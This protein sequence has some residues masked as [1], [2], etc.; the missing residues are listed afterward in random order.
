MRSACNHALLTDSFVVLEGDVQGLVGEEDLAV[1]AQNG[2]LQSG[3][4][5]RRG[6]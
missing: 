4:R 5:G 6:G 3:G 2:E 1:D